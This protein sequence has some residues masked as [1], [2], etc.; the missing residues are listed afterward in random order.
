M[1]SSR[2]GVRSK[3]SQKDSSFNE[4]WPCR[5]P[6]AAHRF[7]SLEWPIKLGGSVLKVRIK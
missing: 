2:T 1:S 4:P 5:N 3:L 7:F 6:V